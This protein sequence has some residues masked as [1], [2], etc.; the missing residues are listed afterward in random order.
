MATIDK[1]IDDLV[2]QGSVMPDN[3]RSDTVRA[4]L[5][6]KNQLKKAG[7]I[8]VGTGTNITNDEDGVS[9]E[10]YVTEGKNI[11]KALNEDIFRADGKNNIGL[12]NSDL[13][14]YS[15]NIGIGKDISIIGNN[16]ILI[17]NGAKAPISNEYAVEYAVI[18]GDKASSSAGGIT[19]G[20]NA[21]SA[22]TNAVAIGDNAYNEAESGIVIGSAAATS[23]AISGIALGGSAI[24]KAPNA[25]QI[26][27]GIN[28]FEN[29]LQ[30]HATQ[31]VDGDGY[32]NATKINGV[33]STNIFEN[34]NKTVKNATNVT[35]TIDGR[36]ITDIFDGNTTT[37]QTADSLS[38]KNN[39]GNV[40][41]PMYINSGN[42]RSCNWKYYNGYNY[43]T[44]E[45][46]WKVDVPYSDWETSF[47]G[48]GNFEQYPGNAFLLFT[49]ILHKHQNGNNNGDDIM[50]TAIAHFNMSFRLMYLADN[51]KTFT[52]YTSGIFYDQNQKADPQL[53]TISWI[54]TN[55]F[56]GFRITIPT[57]TYKDGY[58]KYTIR[59][60]IVQQTPWGY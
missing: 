16:N 22:G 24:V 52:F 7:D 2:T 60:V 34:D 14:V 37:V 15:N 42:L 38:Y 9:K 17:G 12:T 53:V 8:Y 43:S 35:G 4:S 25:V 49:I 21:S 41:T 23:K 39:A 26:G 54:N 10:I 32:V 50:G 13:S 11:Q 18:I 56:H 51:Q 6:Y 3:L 59:G 58:P 44:R 45:Q 19:I 55:D 5:E 28:S 1:T 36:L 31:I 48:S 29:S 47:S 46:D 57:G 20:R 33:L 27:K 40:Y 30:F